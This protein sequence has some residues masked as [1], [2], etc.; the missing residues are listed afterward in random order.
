MAELFAGNL[1]FL[2]R[3]FWLFV[4]CGLRPESE[5]EFSWFF[6]SQVR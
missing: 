1:S 6:S 5:S 2:S 3:F 4:C